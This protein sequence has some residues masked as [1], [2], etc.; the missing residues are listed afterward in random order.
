MNETYIRR[1]DYPENGNDWEQYCFK[2]LNFVGTLPF[3]NTSGI[4]EIGYV[5]VR[6]IRSG[7]GRKLFKQ[8]AL[9]F[10]SWSY[11][12][13]ILHDETL[14][15]LE[16]IIRLVHGSNMAQVLQ[17]SDIK[18]LPIVNFL[19]SVG[20]SVAQVTIKPQE[21]NMNESDDDFLSDAANVILSGKINS[22]S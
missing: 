3:K 17:P 2:R 21:S 6:P 12:T 14:I 13:D 5:S 7:I 18:K 8:L 9:D 15:A 11:T 1:Y 22:L 4:I 16:Q 19:T 20:L 10:P